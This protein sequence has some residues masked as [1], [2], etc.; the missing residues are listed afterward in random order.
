MSFGLVYRRA[1]E[2]SRRSDAGRGGSWRVSCE[3]A[4]YKRPSGGAPLVS[5]AGDGCVSVRDR[6]SRSVALSHMSGTRVSLGGGAGCRS[7]I[8][9]EE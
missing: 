8:N 1:L 2:T 6:W 3:L 5:D 4:G 9:R 7:I